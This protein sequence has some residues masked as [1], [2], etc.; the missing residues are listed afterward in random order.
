MFSQMFGHAGIK[1][2]GG[3]SNAD[4]TTTTTTKQDKNSNKKLDEKSLIKQV[5]NSP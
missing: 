1:K 3:N 2:G 5:Y 4:K